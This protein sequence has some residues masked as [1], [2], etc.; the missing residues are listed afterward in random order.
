MGPDD[1]SDE[2]SDD[3]NLDSSL[4]SPADRVWRH[5]SEMAAEARASAA[6]PT[7]QILSSTTS[8]RARGPLWVTAAGLVVGIVMV[9]LIQSSRTRAPQSGDDFAAAVPSAAATIALPTTT[10]ATESP[11]QTSTTGVPTTYTSP[12]LEIRVARPEGLLT[13]YASDKRTVLGSAV[14]TEN[15]ILTSA[16]SMAGHRTVYVSSALGSA[17]MWKASLLGTDGFSDLAVFTCEESLVSLNLPVAF[18]GDADPSEKV[19]VISGGET[20]L[21]SAPSGKVLQLDTTNES[22]DGYRLAGIAATSVEATG[23]DAGAGLFDSHGMLLGIVV[24]TND[25]LASVLPIEDALALA[26]SL[27]TTGWMT[28]NWA[29]IRGSSTAEGFVIV[30]SVGLASPAELAGVMLGDVVLS[31]DGEQVTSMA[32][33]VHYLRALDAG[34]TIELAVERNSELLTLQVLL[35]RDSVTE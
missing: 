33:L 29:G 3:D 18:L 24:S 26:K 34:S 27:T 30:E 5:P 15:M 7:S 28:P 12:T 32:D 35:G 4:P 14:A 31:V 8:M 1:Y 19:T 25:H 21:T 6:S 13:V 22:A 23:R 10:V 17:S 2:L 11:T 9:G 20:F 16:S